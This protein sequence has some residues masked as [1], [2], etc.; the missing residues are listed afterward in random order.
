[1]EKRALEEEIKRLRHEA[2]FKREAPSGFD[3]PQFNDRDETD[4]K[5]TQIENLKDQI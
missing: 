2:K 5:D 1:M 4:F 3:S